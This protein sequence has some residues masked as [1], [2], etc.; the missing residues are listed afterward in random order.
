MAKGLIGRHV[1]NL[2]RFHM[3]KSVGDATSV[4]VEKY[5]TGLIRPS[6]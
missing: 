3:N 4:C 5:H 1:G 6:E 2:F